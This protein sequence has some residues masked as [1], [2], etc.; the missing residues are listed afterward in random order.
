LLAL[1]QICDKLKKKRSNCARQENKRN[2]GDEDEE[3]CEGVVDLACP[4]RE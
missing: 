2:A 1:S 4:R 3:G